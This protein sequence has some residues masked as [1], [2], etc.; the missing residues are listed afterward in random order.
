M[1][2]IEGCTGWVLHTIYAA[3]INSAYQYFVYSCIYLE[4]IGKQPF[5][6]KFKAQ[7]IPRPK[8]GIKNAEL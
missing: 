2:N 1:C 3:L 5:M 6:K 8:C 4:T 7:V